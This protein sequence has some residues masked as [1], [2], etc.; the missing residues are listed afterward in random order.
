MV[1]WHIKVMSNLKSGCFLIKSISTFLPSERI[2]EQS[3]SIFGH[4]EMLML[5]VSISL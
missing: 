4:T 3:L 2:S 5:T 1:N